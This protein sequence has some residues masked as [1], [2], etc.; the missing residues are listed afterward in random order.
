LVASC[1][2]I[3]IAKLAHLPA[4]SVHFW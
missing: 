4:C 3:L 2:A 1:V